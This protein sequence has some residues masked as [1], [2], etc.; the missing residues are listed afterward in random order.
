MNNF[1]GVIE[2]VGPTASGKT[3]AAM[4]IADRFPV[5][6]VSVDSALVY[7]GMNIGTAKPDQ[8]TLVKY[9]HRLID[10]VD[11]T[12]SYSVQRFLIDVTQ[13]IDDIRANGKVPL[14]V[15]GT[16]LYVRALHEGLS[17]LPASEPAVRAAIL[18]HAAQVGW[19]ALHTELMTIDP[20]T[21]QR[22]NP[23]DAQR[24]GR[25]LEVAQISQVP[26]STLQETAMRQGALQGTVFRIGLMP[27]DRANLHLRIA[28]RFDAMLS[29]GLVDEVV[30]LRTQFALHAELPSMRC[31]GYR[32]VW[33]F[34]EGRQN[35]VQLRESGIAAT[36][37]LAKRQ[38]TWMRSMTF[39]AVIDSATTD[40]EKAAC[41]HVT[42]CFSTA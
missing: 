30:A 42:R 33:D 14:L 17:A 5:E 24:I 37:Q 2:L 15:G 25:A 26:M 22:L 12:E 21:A 7:R 39:D 1:S 40:I 9:P 23:N 28:H 4:A 11:P 34:L 19:P 10:L 8:A 35:A 32:Q 36:R 27:S 38:L 16:M 20:V 29:Q 31:V 3:A 6:I 13:T 18:A 41:D